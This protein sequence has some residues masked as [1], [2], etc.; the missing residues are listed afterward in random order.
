MDRKKVKKA[1]RVFIK[2]SGLRYGKIMN[3]DGGIQF[4]HLTGHVN[5][6]RLDKEI[7]SLGCKSSKLGDSICILEMN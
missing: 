3:F 2:R 5:T 4:M 6:Y 1:V 7:C